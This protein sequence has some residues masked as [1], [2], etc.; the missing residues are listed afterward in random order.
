LDTGD[1]GEEAHSIFN[2]DCPFIRGAD[3]GN[4]PIAFRNPDEIIARHFT[5]KIAYGNL[6]LII[7]TLYSNLNNFCR[8]G[9]ES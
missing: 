4:I 2:P 5:E 6:L 8:R 9:A 1:S 7:I 3:V